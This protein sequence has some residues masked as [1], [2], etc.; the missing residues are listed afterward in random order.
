VPQ[1]R[2]GIEIDGRNINVLAGI[3]SAI[4]YSV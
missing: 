1:R 4:F 3:S 2:K